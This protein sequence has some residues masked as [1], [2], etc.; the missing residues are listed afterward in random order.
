MLW[1]KTVKGTSGKHL[2][3]KFPLIKKKFFWGSGLWSG[4]KYIYSVGRDKKFVERY[5]AKQKYFYVTKDQS[6]LSDF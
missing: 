3:E 4:T 1:L 6:L 2:L 5:V